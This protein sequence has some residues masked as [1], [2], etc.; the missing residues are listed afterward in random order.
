MPIFWARVLL[1]DSTHYG[2]VVDIG[3]GKQTA[4]AQQL[5]YMHKK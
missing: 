3:R 5:G 1:V 4:A 2:G